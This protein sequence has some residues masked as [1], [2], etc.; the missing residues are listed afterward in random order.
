[1]VCKRCQRSQCEYL[2]IFS[3][4]HA[5]NVTARMHPYARPHAIHTPCVY[6]RSTRYSGPVHFMRTIPSFPH[7]DAFHV[8]TRLHSLPHGRKS[9]FPS[10]MLSQRRPHSFMPPTSFSCSFLSLPIHGIGAPPHPTAPHAGFLRSSYATSLRLLPLHPSPSSCDPTRNR[11]V[12][13]PSLPSSDRG[14]ENIL[15]RRAR[16]VHRR[17]SSPRRR[18]FV[19]SSRHLEASRADSH[20]PEARWV[21]VE[22]A[23]AKLETFGGRSDGFEAAGVGNEGRHV[24]VAARPRGRHASNGAR[25]AL[26]GDER[27]LGTAAGRRNPSKA[28]P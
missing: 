1:M 9:M 24:A 26:E 8:S 2:S 10:T 25:F 3:Q 28:A 12:S 6:G 22:G 19:A 18:R 4:D 20:R 11:T 14:G 21:A 16:D 17:A 23:G 7:E 15:Q 27:A 5:S 13:D